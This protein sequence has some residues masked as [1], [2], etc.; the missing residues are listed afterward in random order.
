MSSTYINL[1]SSNLETFATDIEALISTT[2]SL[3]ITIRDN[4]DQI[5]G[6]V[7]GIEG[8]IATTNSILTSISGF[9]DQLE[10]Y[11]DGIEGLITASNVLLTSIDSKLG[12]GNS[13]SFYNEISSVATSLLSTILTYTVPPLTTA[14]I[15]AVDVSGTNIA[16]YTI[17]VNSSV[18]DKR[19]TYFGAALNEV[20][21]LNNSIQLVASDVVEIKVI[22][23]RP[24]MGDFNARL[25]VTEHT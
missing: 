5:E 17:E 21:D 20:F 1:P 10:G 25:E 16:E 19:R 13:K 4:A 7:D 2:N 6:F 8:L 3:L 12:G 23:I 24:D 11:T 9:V 15:S 22:H 18:V 14:S